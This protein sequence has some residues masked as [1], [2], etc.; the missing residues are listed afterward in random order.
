MFNEATNLFVPKFRF[1]KP[2]VKFPFDFEEWYELR[3]EKLRN[4][5]LANLVKKL[6]VDNIISCSDHQIICLSK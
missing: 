1:E 6:E 2:H 5:E 3:K 4:T